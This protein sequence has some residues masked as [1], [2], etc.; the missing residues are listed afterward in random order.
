MGCRDV[1]QLGVVL[2]PFIGRPGLDRG[3]AVGAAE[4]PDRDLELLMKT[5]G[6]GQRQG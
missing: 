4:D 1:L 5:P 2:E 3:R 6:E